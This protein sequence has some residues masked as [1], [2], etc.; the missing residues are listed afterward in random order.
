ME[1]TVVGVFVPL[2]VDEFTI[3]VGSGGIKVERARIAS[4]TSV[5]TPEIS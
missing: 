4:M 2:V 5:G 1:F 3:V